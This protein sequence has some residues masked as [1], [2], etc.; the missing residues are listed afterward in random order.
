MYGKI[1]SEV[2]KISQ[3]ETKEIFA[4]SLKK[5]SNKKSIE[6]ISVKDIVNDCGLTKT[7]FY[8]H[9]RD[10]FDLAAWIYSTSAEKIMN[11]I[12]SKNYS[13]KDSLTD[14]INYFFDNRIFLK[15]LMLN[16][17]GQDSFINYVANFN[18]KILSDYIKK[19]HNLKNLPKDIEISIKIYCYGT[20]CTIC[21]MLI[22]DFPIP[23]ENFVK[24]LENALPEPLKKFLY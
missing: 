16:T 13:W 4:K 11:K 15:N 17:K 6:K 23:V 9:F 24:L 19:V 1:F 21:E 10:K 3:I 7:T 2:I 22:K 20:V 12:I 8:N 14:G 5:L 18:V